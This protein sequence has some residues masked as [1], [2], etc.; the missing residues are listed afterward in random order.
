MRRGCLALLLGLLLWGC[1][2]GP[3]EDEIKQLVMARLQAEFGQSI[4]TPAEFSVLDKSQQ[5][6]GLYRIEVRYTLRFVQDFDELQGERDAD[7]VYDG[8]GK[9]HQDLTMM[10]LQSRYGEFH[11]GDTRQEET[12]VW[13]VKTEQG[14]RLA[15]P[16]AAKAG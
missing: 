7:V 9:F 13:L 11:M 6:E 16:V 4:A 12:T 1:S 2:S 14:W 5:Q 3:G 10:T 15:Q 8:N